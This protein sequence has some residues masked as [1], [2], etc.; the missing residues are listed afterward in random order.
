M[1][2]YR[3]SEDSTQVDEDTRSRHG[4]R[5]KHRSYSP[6]GYASRRPYVDDEDYDEVHEKGKAKYERIGAVAVLCGLLLGGL[7]EVWQKEKKDRDARYE[8]DYRRRRRK[9]FER[10]KAA[11]RRAEDNL[12]RRS[13]SDDEYSNAPSDM[14]RIVYVPRSARSRSTSRAPR[15]I[16]PPPLRSGR[17]SRATSRAH[18][19]DDAS[20]ESE[21]RDMSR[22]R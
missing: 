21:G 10:A 15:R 2:H 13:E 4:S 6:E 11:R 17:T 19:V 12:E 16:E 14:K 7:Y 18:S 5:A 8:R 22:P 20:Y 3:D 9:E 1:P